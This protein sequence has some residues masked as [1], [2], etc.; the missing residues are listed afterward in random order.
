MPTT[1]T[2]AVRSKKL[3][4]CWITLSFLPIVVFVLNAPNYVR[5]TTFFWVCLLTLPLSIPG[6]AGKKDSRFFIMGLLAG[7]ATI[8]LPT[9]IGLFVL[10]LLVPL[11]ILESTQGI[12]NPAI[13]VHIFLISPL[14]SYFSSL[15]SFPLRWQLSQLT[16]TLLRFGGFDVQTKGNVVSIEGTEFLID[17]ACAGLHMLG[18]GLLTGVLVI[19]Y[20][21]RNKPISLGATSCYFLLLIALILFGNVVRIALLVVFKVMPESWLHEGLG[22]VIYILEII[23]PFYLIIRFFEKRSTTIAP[24]EMV[25]RKFPV[26][27]YILLIMLFFIGTLRNQAK[28]TESKLTTLQIPGSKVLKSGTIKISNDDMI[29][30]I[31]PPV[32]PY[33]ANHTPMVC[34]QGSGYEFQ[35]IETLALAQ[36]EINIAELTKGNDRLYTAWWFE[37]TESQTGNEWEW[38]KMSFKENQSFYLINITSDCKSKLM[39][40]LNEMIEQKTIRK[41]DDR[42]H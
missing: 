20:F 41:Y 4:S 7:L 26:W 14:F 9:N 3:I 27:K 29:M 24:K 18:Y 12:A 33:R 2:T 40:H 36:S 21:N 38:R 39:S 35:K 19:G 15:V 28:K 16:S 6:K 37:S 17:E 13:L 5:P 8:L 1:V 42:T 22:I 34:W 31:K 30:F 25:Y 10:S 11:M 32:A 23:V